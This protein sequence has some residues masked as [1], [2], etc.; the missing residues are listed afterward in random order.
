MPQGMIE[1]TIEPGAF[2]VH[3]LKKCEVN[4]FLYD[5]IKVLVV[6][7]NGSKHERI[8]TV[9]RNNFM[10]FVSKKALKSTSRRA[11]MKSVVSPSASKESVSRRY[12]KSSIKDSVKD[13]S[14]NSIPN[15][16]LGFS[17]YFTSIDISEITSMHRSS[18]ESLNLTQQD[19]PQSS[20]VKNK[21]LTIFYNGSTILDLILME[22][23]RDNLF[24]A[25]TNLITCYKKNKINVT[26][27]EILLRYY[28]YNMKTTDDSL[29]RKEVEALMN[30][31]NIHICERSKNEYEKLLTNEKRSYFR[32]KKCLLTHS[33]FIEFLHRLKESDES[34]GKSMEN[35]IWERFFGENVDKVSKE[36][37][38]KNFLQEQERSNID[39]IF[40]V[41]NNQTKSDFFT[42]SDYMNRL[43]FGSFLHSDFNQA[44]NVQEIDTSRMDFPLTHYWISSSHNTYSSGNQ[45][46]I[47]DMLIN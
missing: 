16:R 25:I 6:D 35:T 17:K 20:D 40:E 47:R 3:E 44:F 39:E 36:T 41:F 2:L 1:R 26:K 46:I 11:A 45:V 27:E 7:Q 9:S 19:Y 32:R 38:L 10:L 21:L 22:R 31:F 4:Q 5:G 14:R 28:C 33:N 12:L 13:I 42:G 29:N 8:V 18:T 43:Q 24:K 30:S 37:F 15:N 34:L 23:D